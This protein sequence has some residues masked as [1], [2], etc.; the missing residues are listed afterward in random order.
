ME[1][2]LFLAEIRKKMSRN[3]VELG[4]KGGTL[5][6]ECTVFF[7]SPQDL[8]WNGHKRSSTKFNIA[9][10]KKIHWR[11]RLMLCSEPQYSLG[12]LI[13]EYTIFFGSPLFLKWNRPVS[14]TLR[15]AS[16]EKVPNGLSRCHTKNRTDARGCAHSSFGM[17]P[18]FY[19]LLV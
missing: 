12:T 1:I 18:T 11:G 7:G 13:R 2:G 14:T 9:N 10:K 16:H 6:R 8:K 5:I 15:E 17:T 4:Y 19:F 3:S